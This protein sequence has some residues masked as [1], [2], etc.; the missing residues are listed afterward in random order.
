[1]KQSE[2]AEDKQL[3]QELSAFSSR[4]EAI[5]PLCWTG[6]DHHGKGWVE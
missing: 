4:Q 6:Y 1:M 3:E 5:G 2:T